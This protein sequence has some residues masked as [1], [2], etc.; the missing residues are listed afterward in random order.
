MA[1]LKGHSWAGTW[2]ACV[3]LMDKTSWALALLPVEVI[4]FLLAS[5]RSLARTRDASVESR[6][7][8][9]VLLELGFVV[10]TALACGFLGSGKGLS[11]AL[12][13]PAI[14]AAGMMLYWIQHDLISPN[15]NHDMAVVIGV[16]LC[17]ICVTP[18]C[19]KITQ[20]LIGDDNVSAQHRDVGTLI[21]SNPIRARL[22]VSCTGVAT[23]SDRFRLIRPCSKG[24]PSPWA[25]GFMVNWVM[26][27]WI[28]SQS[29]APCSSFSTKPSRR[30]D[31]P[32]RA[33]S[34]RG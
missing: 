22:S 33:R 14:G 31:R 2:I 30:P 8:E 3:S 19:H 25:A 6:W 1:T 23:T 15:S 18:R 16:L 32:G 5:Y 12:W 26:R 21:R 10:G 17:Q 13:S 4:I 20:T 28:A 7:R 24:D 29:E 9:L 11:G 27:S 34:G